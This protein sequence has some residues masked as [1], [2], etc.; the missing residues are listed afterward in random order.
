MTYTYRDIWR[1][2]FPILLS[3]LMEQLIG[4]TDTAFLGRVGEVE[5]GASA[6]GSTFY[7]AIFML[8]LGFGMGVKIMI[9]RRNGEGRYRQ[10]GNIFYH[11]LAFLMV[12][13]GV[14]YLLTRS[15]GE[16][17][18]SNIISSPDVCRAALDY[19]D[20]RILGFFVS[21]VAILFREFYV[22]TTNTRTLT[23]NSVLMVASNV[24]FNY[25]LIFGN[26]GFPVL[27]IAGAAL[28]SVLA[29]TVSMLFFVVHTRYFIDY[30]KYGLHI[31]PRFRFGMLGRLL[32]LSVWTMVQNFLSL[33]TWFLFFLAVE[34]LGERDLAVTNIIRSISSFFFM[35]VIALASTATALVSNLI[36]Q[37]K[38]DEVAP[39]LCRT[40]RLGFFILVPFLVLAAL[41]PEMLFR[42]FTSDAELI[43]RAVHP[44]YVLL[45]SYVL[46]IPAQIYFAS[47]SG[48][49]NTRTALAFEFVV[50]AIYMVFV[51]VV[52]FIWRADLA[53]CW[54]SEHVY[55]IMAFTLS[56][57]YIR[58]GRWRG[59]RI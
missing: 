8:G 1:I 52:I 50:L 39:I 10:I 38:P 24:L 53:V 18:M 16:M 40:V 15:F 33:S 41:F 56:Y 59:R 4:L 14:L 54:L 55:G 19:L 3:A 57:A 32:G 2:A 11:S 9:A 31:L 23:M 28:G 37:G 29:E 20:W 45:S 21:F 26:F 51:T 6:I 12:L 13:A 17:V 48:T 27:G 22:G 49:G 47:V 43:Q 34:H 58:S 30:R 35:T 44:L 5:L 36:G 42:I 46:T 25:I 7:I